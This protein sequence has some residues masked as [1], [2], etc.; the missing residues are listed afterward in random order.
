MASNTDDKVSSQSDVG[1]SYI[2]SFTPADMVS[3]T[4]NNN[5]LPSTPQ[6]FK[7]SL[8][9]QLVVGN[10]HPMVTKCKVGIFKSKAYVVTISSVIPTDIH[11]AVSIPAW[12]EAVHDELNALVCNKT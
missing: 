12:Q 1:P 11:E 6:V 10:A 2:E 4:R 3:S 7:S 9:P 5:S 8:A